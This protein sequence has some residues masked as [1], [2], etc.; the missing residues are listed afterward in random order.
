MRADVPPLVLDRAAAEAAADAALKARGVTLG[1]EWRR[2]STVRR[3]SDESSWTQHKFVWR[4]AGPDAYRELIDATL[5]PPLWDVRYATFRGDVAARAE[6]WRITIGPGGKVRQMRHVLPEARPGVRLPKEAALALAEQHL[7]E[8]FDADP[9][10]LRLVAAEERDRPARAD[11]SFVFADPRINVGE[12]GEARIS[13][14]LA[15]D[16]IV[17]AARY[18]HVPEPWL[19]AERE[20]SGRLQAAKI[21]GALLFSLAGLAALIFGVQSWLR[22]RCDTRA[23]AIVLAITLGAAAG[24]IAVMW[25][26]VA[27]QLRTTEPILWQVLLAVAGALLAAGF[28]A[29]AIALAAGVGA[30]AARSASGALPAGPLPPW[31]AGVAA[32]L[33]VAGA[34]A[35][36]TRL[37]PAD[38]P[39]WP[40][41][42]FESAAFPWAAAAL[43]GLATI[44]SIGVGLFLLHVLDR[45]TAAWTRRS[46]FA[47]ATV[48][49][50]IAGIVAVKAGE[51]GGALAEGVGSGL[52]AAAVVYFV[53]RF[54]ARTVPAYLV[55]AGLLDA[56]ENAAREGTAAGWAAFAIAGAVSVAVGV[57]ATRYISRPLP[58]TAGS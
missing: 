50:L 17:G 39:L 2:F 10:A 53:L 42:A 9:A 27:M 25:P 21:A 14:T 24:S 32:A 15:G 3:A 30:W 6:E 41:L 56:A 19:R 49:A 38:A 28:A 26:S 5:A 23:L 46:W 12:D 7:R 51:A 33:F 52:F 43:D 55:T 57:A 29:L 4:E 18:V 31:G 37:V 36:A 35:L 16:E 34:G 40:S 45:V 58:V 54:D 22:S 11:W 13:V 48:A 1:P 44:S 8:R 47:V 20:R